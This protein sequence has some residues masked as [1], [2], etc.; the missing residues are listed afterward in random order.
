M[1]IDLQLQYGLPVDKK[2]PLEFTSIFF[3]VLK[4]S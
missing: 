4:L 1:Q 2:R 3:L